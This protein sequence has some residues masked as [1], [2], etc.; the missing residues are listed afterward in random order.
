[1]IDPFPGLPRQ[2]FGLILADPPWQFSTRSAKGLKKS[3]QAHYGCMPLAEIQALPVADLAA[4]DCMLVMW[5]TGPFL[6]LAMETLDAWGFDYRTMGGWGKRSTTGAAWA[7]GTGYIVRSTMEPYLFAVRGRPRQAV[8]NV[9]NFMEAP[10]REHSRKPDAMHAD[11]ER[12]FPA[13]P[14]L[15]LFARQSREGWTTWG[16]QREKFDERSAA[17]TAAAA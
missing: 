13:V 5:T 14:R 17:D 4:P 3:P 2:H 12:M 16:N 9:R 15:E 6:R 10:R 1:M 11:L 7:F 8:R